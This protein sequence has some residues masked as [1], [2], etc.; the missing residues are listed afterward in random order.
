MG[1]GWEVVS[2]V[3]NG[4]PDAVFG[5]FLSGD[6][7]GACFVVRIDTSNAIDALGGVR[8]AFFTA[9]AGHTFD[10]EFVPFHG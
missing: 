9:V 6:F 4:L 10:L 8:D 5:A 2:G 7:D 1:L 3:V